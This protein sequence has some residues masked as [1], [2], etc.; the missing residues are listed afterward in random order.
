MEAAKSLS[1]SKKVQVIAESTALNQAGAD[2]E[3]ASKYA[4]AK[5]H[6]NQLEQLGMLRRHLEIK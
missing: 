3:Q 5:Q 6:V 2:T 4:A 1:A